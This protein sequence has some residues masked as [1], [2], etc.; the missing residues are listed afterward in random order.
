MAEQINMFATEIEDLIVKDVR[1]R[2]H[3]GEFKSIRVYKIADGQIPETN[4]NCVN[5]ID[6]GGAD[7]RVCDEA[8]REVVPRMQ[9]QYRLV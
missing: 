5:N 9:R 8:L 2:A 3:C 7:K 1:R 6:Y 4:W